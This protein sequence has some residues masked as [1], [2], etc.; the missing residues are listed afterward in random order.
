MAIEMLNYADLL[1]DLKSHRRPPGRLLSGSGYPD[2]GAM[3]AR[4]WSASIS[5]RSTM[6]LCRPGHRPVTRRSPP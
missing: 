4:R 2:R 5:Q 6:P 3:T 1:P